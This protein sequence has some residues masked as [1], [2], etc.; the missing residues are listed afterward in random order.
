MSTCPYNNNLNQETLPPGVGERRERRQVSDRV[1][2][3][4]NPLAYA[5][6]YRDTG[7]KLDQ[8]KG[9]LVSAEYQQKLDAFKSLVESK[10]QKNFY[11]RSLDKAVDW[12]KKTTD[13]ISNFFSGV[14]GSVQG[15]PEVQ[16]HWQEIVNF[17]KAN[18]Q[19]SGA[20]LMYDF[21]SGGMQTR[22]AD[23][24]QG[25]IDKDKKGFKKFSGKAWAYA[26]PVVIT[27][28]I[29]QPA[30]LGA[31]GGV[32][33]LAKSGLYKGGEVFK[34]VI[35]GVTQG[36]LLEEIWHVGRDGDPIEYLWNGR[37]I[38]D[39]KMD[40]LKDPK[41]MQTPEKL[42]KFMNPETEYFFYAMENYKA[43]PE[44]VQKKIPDMA[45]F[46]YRAMSAAMSDLELKD[47]VKRLEAGQWDSGKVRRVTS[48]SVS[49]AL[50]KFFLETANKTDKE[51]FFAS[52]KK[53]EKQKF[54]PGG[55]TNSEL[56]KKFPGLNDQMTKKDKGV[57][58][59]ALSSGLS[60][61][62][63]GT[64]LFTQLFSRMFF[65]V[66][67]DPFQFIGEW[68]EQGPK[69]VRERYAKSWKIKKDKLQKLSTRETDKFYA[70]TKKN[71]YDKKFKIL[72]QKDGILSEKE[73]ENL[74]G[75]KITNT[76]R[77]KISEEVDGFLKERRRPNI[78]ADEFWNLET[79]KSLKS[80][81]LR[82]EVLEN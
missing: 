29:M 6:A 35:A 65:S 3:D 57:L 11:K 61:V 26:K 36:D 44:K 28:I 16:S 24:Y 40:K 81:E 10:A 15:D 73:V 79:I 64:F 53:I 52:L 68:A 76:Q 37:S 66:S 38:K 67:K 13:D 41:I 69:R 2:D 34:N 17:D 77:R 23:E 33:N 48:M 18:A 12:S 56:E 46:S 8:L 82:E 30:V 60:G 62:A 78:K 39:R 45:E 63:F 4:L 42:R 22:V 47:T 71:Q 74:L 80:K 51:K 54:K 14:V 59:S 7:G 25:M 20:V 70:Y 5:T 58:R 31:A 75:K 9:R 21:L 1:N 50:L 43:H 19:V 49:G 32:V 55:F 27:N 72:S